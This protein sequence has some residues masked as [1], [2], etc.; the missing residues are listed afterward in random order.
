MA[1]LATVRYTTQVAKECFF[2]SFFGRQK[3]VSINTQVLAFCPQLGAQALLSKIFGFQTSG[4]KGAFLQSF[5]GVDLQG[6]W[7]FSTKSLEA[8]GLL[9]WQGLHVRDAS[10]ELV[11]SSEHRRRD[12]LLDSVHRRLKEGHL[13]RNSGRKARSNFRYV[14]TRMCSLNPFHLLCS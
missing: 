4:S 3:N 8:Q 5:L 10:L 6:E 13:F 7:G 11:S 12:L 2:I 14:G 9:A 1:P